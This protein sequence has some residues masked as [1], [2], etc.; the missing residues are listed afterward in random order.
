MDVA[1]YPN[2]ATFAIAGVVSATETAATIKASICTANSTTAEAPAL[3][4]AITKT[5][6]PTTVPSDSQPA[7]HNYEKGSISAPVLEISWEGQPAVML[8]WTPAHT[9]VE[10]NE[11][12]N[13]QARAFTPLV[14]TSPGLMLVRPRHIP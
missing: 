3:A 10:T 1:Q 13:E 14:S 7:L 8:L 4:L 11:L 9:S 12:A 6:T 5:P 2:R